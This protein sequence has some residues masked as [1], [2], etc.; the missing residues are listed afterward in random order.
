[1][2]RGLCYHKDGSVRV[3]TN[4]L[5]LLVGGV[6][7]RDGVL[8]V[9]DVL[10]RIFT[11]AGLYV[12]EME[13]G[14]AS[15][16]YGAHQYDPMVISAQQ[17]L[18]WGDPYVDILI[19]LD[20]DSNPDA[21]DQSNRDTVLRHGRDLKDGGVLLYDSSTGE[22]PTGDLERRGVKVFPIPAR[23]IARDELKKD[24]VKNIIPVGALF[25]LL[26]FD[27]DVSLLRGLLEE[28]FLRKGREIV[29]LNLRAA[30]RGVEVVEGVLAARGWTDAGYRLDALPVDDPRL[31]IA[32]NEALAMGAIAGGCRY[33]AID[34][35]TAVV[36]PRRDVD[37]LAWGLSRLVEDRALR[38]RI[39]RQGQ[40]FVT[41]QFD[42]E[43][44]TTR[45]EALL[46]A[47][48]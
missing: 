41:S 16:I 35:R 48:R 14:Y 7:L 47:P 42:W 24:V 15:T 10:G 27:A 46:Q 34:G 40:E 44:A 4:N 2:A 6:Q 21:K 45:F 30:A 37:A 8:T 33:Y 28:R 1:V 5:K 26:E 20:F 19:A 12:L 43:R 3:I 22:I 17:P 25:R 11:R 39:A 13:R 32:G 23:N 9:T 38:E 18:S 29:D 31:L 36:A